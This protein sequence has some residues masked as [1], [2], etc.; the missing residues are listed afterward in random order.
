MKLYRIA[1]APAG[2]RWQAKQADAD[3]LKREH[4]GTVEALFLAEHG[5]EQFAEF[6]NSMEDIAADRAVVEA[7]EP[8]KP[9][10]FMLKP[11]P[12]ADFEASQIEAFILD[13]ASVAQVERIMCALGCRFGEL[14][15]EKRA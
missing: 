15:K 2:Q 10:P 11:D 7:P 8:E 13:R 14:V 1:A 3:K 12:S 4:G 9:A 6:L 5:R